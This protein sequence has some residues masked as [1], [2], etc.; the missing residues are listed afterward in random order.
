M[1][2]LAEGTQVPGLELVQ[3]VQGC[4]GP[5]PVFTKVSAQKQDAAAQAHFHLACLSISQNMLRTET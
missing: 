3:A 5:I 2:V 1:H 4:P